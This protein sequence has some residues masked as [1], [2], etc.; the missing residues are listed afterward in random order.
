MKML[1]NFLFT[2]TIIILSAGDIYSAPEPSVNAS[3]SPLKGTVG[4]PLTYTVSI[5]G[6]DP[7]ALKIILPEKKIVYPIESK[8]KKNSGDA[9][10]SPAEFV[11][12]YMINNA[13]RNDS[14][15]N[16]II[17][18]MSLTYYRP[19]N[20]TMPEIKISGKDGISIG[21]EIPSVTIEP[22]NS[23]GTFEEIEPPMSLPGN[24]TRLIWIIIAVILTAASAFFLYRYFK[25]KRKP[26][27]IEETPLP[28]IEIFLNEIESLKLKNLI[29]EGKINEYVF[30]ISIVF[31]RF[32]SMTLNFDAAEMTTDEISSRLKKFMPRE[33]Y[34]V[35]GDEIISNMRLWD[36]SKF[37]E[38]APSK[39]LLMNNLDATVS[40]AKKISEMKGAENVS[41]GV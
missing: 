32:L 17:V 41:A 26:V 35:C 10:K 27:L 9:E 18:N 28:P 23:E 31:R 7:A 33:I 5:K 8:E 16:E 15:A 39:E 4:Q 20:H 14:G 22:I 13:S 36:L 34:S 21:Y 38:F 12:L 29:A 11:P 19:G 2:I 3:V 6:I 25:K 37:A 40:V 24:Y 1:K 30:G